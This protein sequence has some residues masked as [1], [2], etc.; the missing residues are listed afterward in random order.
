MFRGTWYLRRVRI[1]L[2][3]D[4]VVAGLRSRSGASRAWLRSGL[5][6]E[7]DIVLTVPLMLQYEAVLNRPE[8][9]D[10]MQATPERVSRFLDLLSAV[11][12]PSG[13][14]YLWRPVLRDPDD[15]M[16]LEAAVNGRADLLL[17][18]NRRDF[19]GSERFGVRVERPGPAWQ[20]WK[21]GRT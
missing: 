16:V 3:T 13:I 14:S 10:G 17:T 20:A 11:G 15:E 7:V 5:R 1:V 8:I 19:A 12:H 4:V 21:G 18:F 9:L 6:R 2:D